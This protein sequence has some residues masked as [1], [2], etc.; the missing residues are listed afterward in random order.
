MIIFM[1]DVLCVTNRSLCRGDFLDRIEQ[2]A[3][4]HPKG[5]LLREKDLSQAEYTRLAKKVL[6]ICR[7][8]QVPCILHSFTETAI[9]LHADAI[10]LPLPFLRQ[11][12]KEQKRFFRIIGASCHSLKDAKEA[13]AL[14]C[15]YITA[16]HIFATGCKKDLPPRGL[17]FLR[18]ICKE[19]AVPVYAIG[20]IDSQKASLIRGAGACGMCVMSG[21]MQCDDAA[22]YLK[23]FEK[24]GENCAVS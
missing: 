5:I 10:H 8:Y 4:S 12:P 17:D 23:N 2:I 15:T 18:T 19:T 21:I 6:A 14:G 16:G 24:A 9:K 20:G 1:S 22:S 3:V 7:T 11:M 13:E